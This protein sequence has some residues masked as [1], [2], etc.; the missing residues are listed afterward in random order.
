MKLI[1]SKLYEFLAGMQRV[2]A[3]TS[4]ARMGKYAQSK[5]VMLA[6]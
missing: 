5:E 1:L 6:K 4:L 3:A 2:R